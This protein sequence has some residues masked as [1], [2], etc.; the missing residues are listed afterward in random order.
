VIAFSTAES[1]RV[2]Y[3]SDQDVKQQDVLR[4]S[5]MSPLF[6]AVNEAT[7]EAIINSLF[8][9]KTMTGRDGHTVEELPTEKVLKVM[10][11]YGRID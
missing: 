4:N 3:R 5:A 6:M 10:E 1:V 2:P 11:K 7:E 9:A 8:H